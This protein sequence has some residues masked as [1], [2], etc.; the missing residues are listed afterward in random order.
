MMKFVIKDSIPR[1]IGHSIIIASNTKALTSQ[2][3]TLSFGSLGG[4]SMI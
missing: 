1:K 4:L 3:N 2:E